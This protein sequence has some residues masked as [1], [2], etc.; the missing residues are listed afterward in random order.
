[1]MDKK[2]RFGMM[3]LKSF[4]LQLNVLNGSLSLVFALINEG[5]N[6]ALGVQFNYG[7]CHFNINTFHINTIVFI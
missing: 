5:L 1:M 3:N 6:E 4:T 7:E 2:L